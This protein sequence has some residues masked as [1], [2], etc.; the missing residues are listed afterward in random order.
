MPCSLSLPGCRCKGVIV[1]TAI[2]IIVG[3]A[4]APIVAALTA[5]MLL[6]LVT[7]LAVELIV[8]GG[9]LQGSEIDNS[10]KA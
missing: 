4:I 1:K 8:P 9:S 7:M 10:K 3:I 2:R 5:G 6:T